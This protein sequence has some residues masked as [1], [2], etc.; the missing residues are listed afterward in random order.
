MHA[1]NDQFDH[2]RTSALGSPFKQM[3]RVWRQHSQ[4]P[5]QSLRRESY[6][7]SRGHAELLSSLGTFNY[8]KYLV[9]AMPII[10][11]GQPSQLVVYHG[12]SMQGFTSTVHLLPEPE[13][14]IFALQNSTAFCDPYD[15]ILQALVETIDSRSQLSTVD[16]EEL[17]K[18]PAATGAGLADEVERKL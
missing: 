9:S 15:W 1:A 8:N 17:A 18:V 16:F 12:G 10:D 11:H 5:I 13:I 14:S 7:L 6:A 4:S 2:Q 3:T